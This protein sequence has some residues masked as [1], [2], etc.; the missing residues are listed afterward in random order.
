MGAT[1]HAFELLVSEGMR[2][3]NWSPSD[4]HPSLLVDRD[5][6]RAEL[7]ED[8]LSYLGRDDPESKSTWAVIGDKGIGKTILTRA[9]L[10]DVRARRS[11]TT[12]IATVDCRERQSWREVLSQLCWALVTE[13]RSLQKIKNGAVSD[14]LITQ[15]QLLD[16]LAKLD[17][18]ELQT[19]HER[20]SSFRAGLKLAPSSELLSA[21]QVDLGL[22]L[23]FDEKKIRTLTGTR[24]FD[25][26]RLNRA[27]CALCRDIRAAGLRVVIYLDN[28]D[29]LDH[30]YHD[31]TSRVR[32]RRDAEGLLRLSN[33][34]V[35]LILNMRTYF[36]RV[37]PRQM[38]NPPIVVEPLPPEDLHAI[39]EKRNRQESRAV[40]EIFGQPDS[41]D[42][43][44]NLARLAPTPFSFLTWVHYLYRREYLVSG[45]LDE[46]FSRYV[47]AMFA[48][49]DERRILRVMESFETPTA[50]VGRERVLAACEGNESLLRVLEDRQV[51]LP[52]DFWAPDRY[53]LDPLFQV[54][55]LRIVGSS[56]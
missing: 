46:G 56:S 22:E 31:E 29:E 17:N 52:G 7:R 38:A 44:G 43:V 1:V 6:V 53:T 33:A 41:R 4:V 55:H 32:V 37:L 20:A 15:A 9:V 40:Q 26:S 28:V 11:G 14:G 12:V 48:T 16:E 8:V 10:E 45:R 54:F 49:I 36:S 19:L 47:K 3:I 30:D 2:Q 27:V 21:L 23:G 35:A 25:E 13:L 42:A 34:P 51:V 18:A 24:A 39:L 50:I 5:E